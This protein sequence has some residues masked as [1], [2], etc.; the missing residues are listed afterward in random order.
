M[1]GSSPACACPAVQEQAVLLDRVGGKA[2][3]DHPPL[4][5]DL[6]AAADRLLRLPGR[7]SAARRTAS[8][9]TCP[10][11]HALTLGAALRHRSAP[12]AIAAP[13][14]PGRDAARRTVCRSQP[15]DKAAARK[16]PRCCGRVEGKLLPRPS[17]E[18]HSRQMRGHRKM[19]D[20]RDALCRSYDSCQEPQAAPEALG[21]QDGVRSFL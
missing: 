6:S 4:V 2:R 21:V 12:P 17:S 11:T 16:T 5:G 7:C 3:R 14:H 13:R 8:G 9:R 15:L 10:G 18:G 19:E 1:F 20:R